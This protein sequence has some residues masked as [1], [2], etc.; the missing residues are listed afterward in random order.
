MNS[1]ASIYIPRIRSTHTEASITY[2]IRRFNIGRVFRVDFTHINKKPGFQ[3]IDGLFMSVFIH[4]SDSFKNINIQFWEDIFAGRPHKL[5]ISNQEFWICL[6]NKNPVQ[7]TRM[8]IHQV[9]ENARHLE[10]VVFEQQKLIEELK[11]KME[12]QMKII[13]GLV[14]NFVKISE[15]IQQNDETNDN[16][17]TTETT[18]SLT[19]DDSDISDPT[20][21]M[22][23][24]HL[25]NDNPF[26]QNHSSKINN[27]ALKWFI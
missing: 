27:W 6:K 9:V 7:F 16:S 1:N 11:N 3:E 8:N 19:D 21:Y 24:N 23:S 4:F 15:N 26:V 18:V 13:D 22:N 2:I 14:E 12:N 10:N 5:E 17:S 20:E 25:N